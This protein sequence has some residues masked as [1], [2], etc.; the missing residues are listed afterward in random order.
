MAGRFR[1]CWEKK[2]TWSNRMNFRLTKIPLKIICIKIC[3]LTKQL[4]FRD[5]TSAFPAKWHLRNKQANSTLTI[6]QY[7]LVVCCLFFKFLSCPL[8]LL[9]TSSCHSY[10]PD[11][12]CSFKSICFTC[13]ATHNLG[14]NITCCFKIEFYF[15]HF[16]AI[17]ILGW[18]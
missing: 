7:G 12:P 15:S 5:A 3:N 11:E 17:C 6:P 1:R 16:L 14:R 2:T 9:Q 13:N 18:R 10:I 8:Q 4:T